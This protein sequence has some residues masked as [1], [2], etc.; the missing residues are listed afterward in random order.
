MCVCERLKWVVYECG[1]HWKYVL[2]S[3]GQFFCLLS[4]TFCLSIL[5]SPLLSFLV[6]HQLNWNAA[7]SGRTEIVPFFVVDL[8]AIYH[9]RWGSIAFECTCIHSH[10]AFLT[11]FFP[12]LPEFENTVSN[13]NALTREHVRFQ[14]NQCFIC[15]INDD[16]RTTTTTTTISKTRPM[17][18][19][20]LIHQTN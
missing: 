17:L 14:C 9:I 18:N 19:E 3:N 8:F 6:L 16:S 10:I 12:S 1:D 7:D 13:S 2:H 5:C 20:L 4:L 11:I 15:S